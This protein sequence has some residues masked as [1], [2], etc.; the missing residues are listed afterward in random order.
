MQIACWIYKVPAVF[1]NEWTDLD[2]VSAGNIIYSIY[3]CVEH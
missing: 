1:Q 2:D 3:N